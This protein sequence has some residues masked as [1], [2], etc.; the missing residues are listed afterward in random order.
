MT[1]P[2]TA[3]QAA[4]GYGTHMQILYGLS[5]TSPLVWQTIGEV[6]DITLPS[7]S[8]D[9]IDVTHMHS[10]NRTR[11]FI[12][13]MIDMGECSFTMNYVPGSDGDRILL[14]ILAIPAGVA[15]TQSL[16]VVF[17][18]AET[19]AFSGNL[20]GYA[21]TAPTADKMTATVTWKVTS[22]ITASRTSPMI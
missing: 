12:D 19:R 7:A 17:A 4:I 11:E 20:S 22:L 1:S 14:A 21:P 3:T 6:T 16:R 10:P 13:G 15:R 8:V 5:P 18:N 2:W 9:Q